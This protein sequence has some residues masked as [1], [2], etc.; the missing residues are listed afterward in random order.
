[1]E[2]KV[3][4]IEL[5]AALM[6]ELFTDNLILPL[7]TNANLD[8]I[9]PENMKSKNVGFQYMGSNKKQIVLVIHSLSVDQLSGIQQFINNLLKACKLSLEDVAILN[10]PAQDITIGDLKQHLFPK[11]VLLFG[12]NPVSIGIPI[13]FPQFKLQSY[14]NINYLFAPSVEELNQETEASKLLKSKLWICLKQ[15]FQLQ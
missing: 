11:E 10:Y 15:V 1:M 14:D 9:P 8:F 3:D 6:T 5:T 7:G 4:K 2:T 12:V 13:K